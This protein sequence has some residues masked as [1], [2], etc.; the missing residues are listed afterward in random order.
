MDRFVNASPTAVY[1]ALTDGQTVGL[2]RAP[3]GMT[4]TVHTFDTRR[5]GEFRISLTYD[6]ESRA[7]KSVGNVDTYQGY[8]RELVPDRRIVEVI[9]FET[10]DPEL[11]GEMTITTSL[12]AVGGRTKVVV[13][14]EGLPEGVPLDDNAT[15]TAMSLSKLAK[16]VEGS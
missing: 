16:L 8:F 11:M 9:G 12:E 7:G 10:S 6:D 14:F 5:G 15:G 4:C 13:A 2:W 3:D 1:R